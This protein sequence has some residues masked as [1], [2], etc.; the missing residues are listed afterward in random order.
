[1][2]EEEVKLKYVVPWLRES[3]VNL[4]DLQFEQSFSVKI[5]RQRISVGNPSAKGRAGARLDIL[6]R[7]EDT[8]LFVVETKADSQPLTDGDR[9]QAVSYARL[10]H[11]VAPY[12]VV[13]NGDVYRLYD[14]ITKEEIA[15]ASIP[16]RGFQASL[17]DAAIIEAQK[18]FLG[19]NRSN[20]QVFCQQ[21]VA[22]ELRPVA[23]RLSQGRKYVRELHVARESVGKEVSAL[24]TSSEPALLLV[25]ESGSGK[26]CELCFIAEAL[27][28][29]GKPVLFFNGFS[30]VGDITEAIANEFAWTFNGSDSPIQTLKRIESFVGT[31]FLTVI[32]DAIDEWML[33]SRVSRLGNLLRACEDR[34]IK[35]ILSCKESGSDAFLSDRANP[36]LV[37]LLSK[38]LEIPALSSK[39]FFT[40]IEKYRQEYQFFGAFE[41]AVLKEARENPFLLR[42]L[43]DVAKGSKFKH[44]TF[45]SAEFFRHYFERSL[46][47]T[48]HKRHAEDT[49]VAIGRLLY[50]RNVDSIGEH[51]VKNALGLRLNDA[52]MEELFEYDLLV[53]TQS[54]MGE[55][56]IGFYFQ[57]LRDFI[58]AFG[59]LKLDR[60]SAADLKI[61]FD[62]ATFPSTRGD[63]FS[64]Y[65]RLASTERQQIFD[66]ELRENA[67][68]YL[69]YC[70]ALVH[71]HFS[72]MRT[73]LNPR[74]DKPVGF[75]GEF[76]LSSRRIGLHGFRPLD[77][78][79][80]DIHF[81]PVQRMLNKSNLASLAGAGKMHLNSG[82]NG[83]R[84]GIN[85]RSS[86]VNSELL[87]QIDEL[88]KSGQLNESRN[89]DLLVEL[90][91]ETVLQYSAIFK[92]LLKPDGRSIA[93]PLAL[94]SVL[95][96]ILREKLTRYFQD[97]IVVR[98]RRSGE[99]KEQWSQDSVS[100]SYARTPTDDA[101]VAR[102]VASAIRSGDIPVF[103]TRYTELEYLEKR[104]GSAV[105]TLLLAQQEIGGP[106]VDGLDRVDFRWNLGEFMKSTD[107][108]KASIRDIY[109]RYR[110]N[111]RLLIET[112]FP[113]LREH[114]KEYM[115]P[116]QTIFFQLG[117]PAESDFEVPLFILSVGGSGEHSAEFV[118]EIEHEA[119]D[120]NVAW[121][122][123][124]K[125]YMNCPYTRTSLRRFLDGYGEFGRMHLRSMVY[126][127]MHREFDAVKRAFRSRVLSGQ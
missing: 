1:M 98:K 125:T 58:I 79:D 83:F 28:T 24:Y 112:N 109:L 57:K 91:L 36:T 103:H 25:G 64:L 43:F 110:S 113:S 108:L 16:I 86:V 93:Y 94:P 50:E 63:V 44:L 41:D 66:S 32:V 22:G 54:A 90:I 85:I 46:D 71:E 45:N 59:A 52:L 119:V 49:L 99:I 61:A 5:G 19:L 31:D 87:P 35:L 47:K 118:D 37:G 88:V 51:E 84:N 121:K 77:Q 105:K 42:V 106:L 76:M 30:M 17:P 34:R 114:F 11:P 122:V 10:V 29:N 68:H 81:I 89:P 3:G 20:L 38:K 78:G 74:G 6:V 26:T 9:D 65:Y 4:Q 39:E 13:T 55:R 53:R 14:A 82:D 75:I 101:E 120:G 18:C 48:K 2:N 111:Y 126:G 123:L 33:D 23:G 60:M 102:K 73:E 21:Q 70:V 97:E 124:G 95:N 127:R 27:A 56:F 15:P 72:A 7:R 69:D 67:R 107:Q 96:C 8:N 115:E 12:A 62:A 92:T 117:F 80:E 116:A 40:A 104:L 100:Y